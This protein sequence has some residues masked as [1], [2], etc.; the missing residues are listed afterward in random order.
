MG[1]TIKRGYTVGEVARIIGTSATTMN[2]YLA[3]A[4]FNR[5]ETCRSYTSKQV[6]AW[7]INSDFWD[8]MYNLFSKCKR[9]RKFLGRIYDLR[10]EAQADERKVLDK[11]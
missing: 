11:V 6:R 7:K 2:N 10:R 1:K 9:V 8:E 3:R 5:F 4:E